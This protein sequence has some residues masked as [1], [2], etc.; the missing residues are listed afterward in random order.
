MLTDH[1]HAGRRGHADYLGVAKDLE[2]MQHHVP[3]VVLV[4]GVVVHLAAAGLRLRELHGMA[5][6]FQNRDNSLSR[7]WKKSVVIARDK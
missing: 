3:G 2:K 1:R 4:P 5:Q 6:P 7:G